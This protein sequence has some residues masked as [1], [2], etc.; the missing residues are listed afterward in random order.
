MW[1][2]IVTGSCIAL[3]GLMLYFLPLVT[4]LQHGAN[5]ERNAI[6]MGVRIA[7]QE[8]KDDAVAGAEEVALTRMQPI[9]ND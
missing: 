7:V 6:D 8:S 2:F 9:Y 4:R 3:S 1:P 5:R